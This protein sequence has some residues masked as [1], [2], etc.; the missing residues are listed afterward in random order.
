MM[1]RSFIILP[2]AGPCYGSL[3]SGLQVSDEDRLVHAES[4]GPR[5]RRP[6]SL[7]LILNR[8]HRGHRGH[9]DGRPPGFDREIY[10]RRNLIERSFNRLKGFRGITNR[11]DCEDDSAASVG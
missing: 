10:R 4:G 7:R 8:G 5:A 6:A 2:C 3:R 9:R 1:H 11:Y